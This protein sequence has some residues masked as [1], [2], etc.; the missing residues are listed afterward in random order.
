MSQEVACWQGD[1]SAP[2]WKYRQPIVFTRFIPGGLHEEDPVFKSRPED[3]P[4][5]NLRY[6]L[7]YMPPAVAHRTGPAAELSDTGSRGVD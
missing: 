7:G 1:E 6:I 5:Q 3:V 4:L 2:E